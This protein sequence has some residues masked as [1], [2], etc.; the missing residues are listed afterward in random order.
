M[1]ASLPDGEVTRVSVAR[2]RDPM[3]YGEHDYICV[4][5]LG[6]FHV[7][8]P[9]DTN[10][11]LRRHGP[12]AYRVTAYGLDPAGVRWEVLVEG[13]RAERQLHVPIN[14]NYIS[15]SIDLSLWSRILFLGVVVVER[16]P[17]V[18]VGAVTGSVVV[19]GVIVVGS[20]LC[21][22]SECA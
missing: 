11:I 12:G 1:L 20:S 9:C 10:E 2:L 17:L 6:G 19:A 18:F 8:G 3:M 15:P 5:E 14:D 7:S 13:L 16:S 22:R 21:A 4:T